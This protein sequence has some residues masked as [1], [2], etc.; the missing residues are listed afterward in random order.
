MLSSSNILHISS[1]VNSFVR[2]SDLLIHP[3]CIQCVRWARKPSWL[4]MAKSKLFVIPERPKIDESEKRELKRL[5]DRYKTHMHAIRYAY[6]LTKY[7]KLY[8]VIGLPYC[9]QTREQGFSSLPF[10]IGQ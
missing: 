4:P 3:A 5:H 10:F 1:K 6:I 9:L 7:Y 2:K 8:C